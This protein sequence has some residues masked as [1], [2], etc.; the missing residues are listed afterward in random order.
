MSLLF[1]L[2]IKACLLLPLPLACLLLSF[3]VVWTLHFC[4]FGRSKERESAS[5][6]ATEAARHVSLCLSFHCLIALLLLPRHSRLPFA[7]CRSVRSAFLSFFWV[8]PS[9]HSSSCSVVSVLSALLR[10]HTASAWLSLCQLSLSLSHSLSYLLSLSH[11]LSVAL[12]LSNSFYSPVC[13]FR[14]LLP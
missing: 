10:V 4:L 14:C 6:R 11:S 2:S 1:T 8:T 12:S 7:L 3:I 13:F 9:I 5:E